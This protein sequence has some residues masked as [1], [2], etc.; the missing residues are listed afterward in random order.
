VDRLGG[1]NIYGARVQ[2]AS[3][4]DAKIIAI[5]LVAGTVWKVGTKI[6][7]SYQ[8]ARAAARATRA[9][10][11]SS[12]AGSDIV[13]YIVDEAGLTV[14]A[15]GQIT[16]PHRGRGKGYRPEPVGGRTSGEHRGH[17]IPEGGV[18]SP[19]LVNVPENIISETPGSNLGPKK[20]LDNLVSRIANENP[21]SV[22][23]VIAEPLRRQGE[24]RP[25]AV[26]YWIEKDGV[27]ITGQTILNK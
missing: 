16:G 27:R 7:H 10:K 12:N 19:Q 17:L 2:L 15:E 5:Q 3:A 25:F 26:T 11:A 4:G 9:A 1:E 22:V 21:N 6:Y 13:S 14:R 23:R 8:Q 24:T 20:T 18:D